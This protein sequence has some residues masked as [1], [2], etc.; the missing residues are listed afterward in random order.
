MTLIWDCANL[1][2]SIFVSANKTTLMI[3]GAD[4]AF[5]LEKSM[6]GMKCSATLH[7]IQIVCLSLA[8]IPYNSV[9]TLAIIMVVTFQSLSVSLGG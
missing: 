7:F 9:S 2:L 4:E 8:L 3:A 6:L 1:L 5:K